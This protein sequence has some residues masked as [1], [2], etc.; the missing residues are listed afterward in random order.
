MTLPRCF[1]R[2]LKGFA[3]L[4]LALAAAA[5]A[6][7]HYERHQP[8]PHV[9]VGQPYKING[10]WY[11]P[12]VEPDYDQVGVASWYGRDFHGKPTANGEIFDMNLLSAA[13]TTLPMPS[14]VEVRNLENG[15]SLVVRLNDRGPFADNRLIDLSREAARRLG[16]EEQGLARVRVRYIGPAPLHA[17]A[18]SRPHEALRYAA[19]ARQTQKTESLASAP[20]KARGTIIA[21]AVRSSTAPTA[22]PK[23]R[24]PATES[25]AAFEPVSSS[26]TTAP[27]L[28]SLNREAPAMQTR[29]ET[30]PQTFE[31]LYVIRVAA[32]SRLDNV[33][34]LRAEMAQIGPLRVS[35]VETDERRVFYRVSMG[36]F[37][38]YDT[39][40][41]SLEDV[42]AAG[43]ADASIVAITP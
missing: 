41:A 6:S 1:Q 30:A 12:K 39:A 16:F 25:V 38:A 13:H 31:K 5:C 29:I 19:Q 4:M 24:P 36:P 27:R 11:H 33:E 42:R 7:P 15:R 9:K 26:Q 14:M 28:A 10:R 32:L 21:A 37:N 20:Q 18:P 3:G 23:S 22:P 35:R 40:A 8:G 2:R 17:K 43:Y 34:R